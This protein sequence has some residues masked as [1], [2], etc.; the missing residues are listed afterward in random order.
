MDSGIGIHPEVIPTLLKPFTQ[1][2]SSI[3]RRFGGTGLGLS[4]SKHLL[5]LMGSEIN[6]SSTFGMGSAF[7]FTLTLPKAEQ[8]QASK[9]TAAQSPQRR[10]E[11]L[12]ILAV[13]DDEASL[14][15]LKTVLE[16]EGATVDTATNG[17]LACDWLRN[18]PGQIHVVLM[19]IQ[20]PIMDGI[21][22]TRLIRN[23]LEFKDLPILAVT[24]GILPD[25]QQAA[26]D[27]GITEMIR[28][29]VDIENLVERLNRIDTS[30]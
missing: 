2:D 26:L 9:A 4:I 21:T 15:L 23:E 7:A 22:A 19:D 12:R 30:R 11:G 13:D 27:A 3:T 16:R 8:K 10:L 24:A 14:S 17:Q 28:K 1:A 29:P 6:I 20:M 25:Q 18:H 5:E